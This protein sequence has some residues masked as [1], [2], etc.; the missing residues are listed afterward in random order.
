LLGDF[1]WIE[2]HRGHID[3]LALGIGTPSSRLGVST[4]L[5]TRFPDLEWPNLIHPRAEIDRAS[6]K[7]GR[8]TM[9]AAGVTGTV[10]IQ[11]HDFALINA[12]CTLGHEANIGRGCV[13]NHAASISGGV[14]LEDGVLVGTGA[15]ILQYLH[16]GSGSTVGAGAV[17]T[18]DVPAQTTVVGVPAQP[19]S[20]RR[21]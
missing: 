7:L 21:S 16:V 6:L 2:Q 12:G 9:L 14:V 18:K 20:S 17:V 15:R 3:A 5:S 11:L 1:S 4:E 8:G 10:N 13:V 19:I